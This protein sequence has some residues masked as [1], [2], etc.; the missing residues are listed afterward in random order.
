MSLRSILILFVL[1]QV[2]L[3]AGAERAC[4]M[5]TTGEGAGTGF[6]I[7]QG[8]GFYLVSNQHVIDGPPPHKYTKADGEELKPL[9][10]WVA[11]DRDIVI[12]SLAGEYPDYLET[13]TDFDS[14]SLGEEVLIYGNSQGRGMRY[15]E[16][17]IVMKGRSEI[18]ISGGIVPGN[19]GGPI[20]RKKNGKMLAVATYAT[21]QKQKAS[22]IT[23]YVEAAGLP[24]VR[25]YGVRIDTISKPIDFDLRSFL[26]E[27]S[28]LEID[29]K[30]L[31]RAAIM[32][33]MLYAKIGGDPT[34]FL[35]KVASLA[36][37]GHQRTFALLEPSKFYP[38]TYATSTLADF[39]RSA[40]SY[41][42]I[43]AKP[44]SYIHRQKQIDLANDRKLLW[45]L[46]AEML[47]NIPVR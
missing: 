45:A 4:L 26:V 18:E 9:K 39:R 34:P 24:K 27:S 36:D 25:F 44:V 8:D 11:A 29:R 12:Y 31:D 21:V 16:A 35:R 10:G 47:R 42:A 22:N 5:M 40:D 19:S 23:E 1:M 38:G 7:K 33:V 37:A 41:F 14:I 28:Q 3:F 32:V 17:K 15:S 6:I 30:Q 2:S 13:E 43:S 46:Y 20:I